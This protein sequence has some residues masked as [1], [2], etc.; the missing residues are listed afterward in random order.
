MRVLDQL[1]RDGKLIFNKN[2]CGKESNTQKGRN[3]FKV[4]MIHLIDQMMDISAVKNFEAATDIEVL[5]GEAVDSVVMNVYL[6]P[7]DSMEKIYATVYVRG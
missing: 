1:A 6:Q 7:V 2:Y 4:E 5:P 3:N